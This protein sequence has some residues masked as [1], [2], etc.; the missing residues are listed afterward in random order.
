M[1]T[2]I[3]RHTKVQGT[4][5]P[6]D[7]EWLYWGTRLGKDPTKPD[8]FTTLL[9]E[10]HGRCNFCGALFT[11]DD[12]I[13]VHHKN[14]NRNDNYRRNLALLHGHCHDQQHAAFATKFGI[15]DNN[16]FTEEPRL[17]GNRRKPART[18]LEQRGER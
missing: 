5:S 12:I 2:P 10:Q 13:E 9:K 11:T 8:Y 16:R 17:R 14:G 7:G 1:I 6:F 18:V 4:R 3:R 15:G